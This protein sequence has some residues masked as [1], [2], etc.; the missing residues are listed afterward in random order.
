MGLHIETDPHDIDFPAD[1]EFCLTCAIPSRLD[2]PQASGELTHTDEGIVGHS[3]DER[4][5]I[6]A[7]DRQTKLGKQVFEAWL[8]D[9]NIGYKPLLGKYKGEVQ[10]SYI[11]NA[12]DWKV[13]R[14]SG[15]VSRQ[16]SILYLWPHAYGYVEYGIDARK[17]TLYDLATHEAIDLGPFI[18]VNTSEID[19]VYKDWSYDINHDQYYAVKFIPTPN[20]E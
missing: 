15:F 6:V 9:L 3:S 2:V 7:I 1:T 8:K 11:V 14:M 12:R 16:E 18:A 19:T 17:A 10:Y 4:Y 5:V 13:V 20:E